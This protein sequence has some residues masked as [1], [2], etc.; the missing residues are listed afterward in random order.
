[1]L[2]SFCEL[3]LICYF[4]L[5][6]QEIIRPLHYS[7]EGET[8]LHRLYLPYI[9]FTLLDLFPIHHHDPTSRVHLFRS[10]AYQLLTALAYIHERGISHRDVNPKNVMIT[11]TGQVQL[12]DFST[13]FAP[14][15]HSTEEKADNL[16]SQVGTG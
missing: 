14:D 6:D 11:R 10:I 8:S 3:T 5:A 16:F 15:I 4:G 9:P 13:S 12:I 2:P 7:F 1:M